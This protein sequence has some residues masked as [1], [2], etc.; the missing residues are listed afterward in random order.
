L[1]KYDPNSIF[2]KLESVV[3]RT[4]FLEFVALLAYDH[5]D[6]QM[7]EALTP[8]SPYGPGCNGWENGTIGAFLDASVRC[9]IA[10][11]SDETG[12]PETASWRAF[13]NFLYCGKIYE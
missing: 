9:A 10:H 7:R 4:T 1:K 12:L 13:A 5:E 3:D 11:G 2:E 6:E 8:S